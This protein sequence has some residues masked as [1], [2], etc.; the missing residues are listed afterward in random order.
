MSKKKITLNNNRLSSS[1]DG[2]ILI[3]MS[4]GIFLIISIFTFFLMKL[5]VKEHNMSMLH[6][7]DVKTRNLS[8]SAMGRGVFQFNNF[9]DISSQTG[10]LN[11]GNY[12]ISY[13][14][15]NDENNNPLPYSHYT[16]LKSEA[17]I[18]NSNRKTRLFLSSF[19]TGFNPAFYGENSNNILFNVNNISGG[20][21][22]KKDGNLYHNGSLIPSE[23]IAEIMPTFNNFYDDEIIWTE[24]N[25][26]PNTSNS[27]G[28]PNNRFLSFEGNDYAKVIYTSTTTTTTTTP[29]A[30]T[31]HIINFEGQ[32]WQ[33]NNGYAGMNW[34]NRFYAI[35]GSSYSGSGYQTAVRSGSMAAFNAWN[36]QNI[37]FQTSDGSMFNFTELYA[38]SAW[39]NTQ[40][41]TVKG[42]RNNTQVYSQTFNISKSTISRLS[43][44]FTNVNKIQFS[45]S[46]SHIAMDDFKYTKTGP[47]TTTTTTTTITSLPK[48]NEQRTITAWVKPSDN[49]GNAGDIVNTGRTNDNIGNEFFG[50]GRLGDKLFFWGGVTNFTS[51]LTVPKGEW[52]FI[53]ARYDGYKIRLYVNN[54]WQETTLNNFDTQISELFIGGA[55]TNNGT[56]F[57]S[58]FRGGIDEVAV[59][60]ESLSHSE[61]L[62]LYNSGSGNNASINSGNY[63]SKS[64][65]KGY[66]KLNEGGGNTLLDASGNNKN[67]TNYGS[68]WQTGSH[69]QPQ[70]RPLT[71]DTGS[72][73][74]L[75]SPNCGS[76]HTSLCINNKIAV[77][78]DIV[79]TDTDITGSG[80]I[81]STGKITINENSTLNGDIIV[82]AKTIDIT[83]SS[84]GNSSLF[85]SANGPVTIYFE[86][87]GLISNSSNISGFI[88]N[89]GSNNSESF[90]I[91]N[92]S[93]SGAI[94]NYGVNFSINNN[95]TVIGSIVSNYLLSIDNSSNIIKGN[96]PSFYGKNI[97][98]SPSV[99][100]GS[101]LEY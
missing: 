84:L 64:N 18:N 70:I 89:N 81:V 48:G 58:Y 73:L 7:L 42:F 69:T 2:V 43:M 30:T 44:N 83:N 45:N 74:N 34:H 93:I 85:K 12:E 78:Q 54:E 94:L 95:S 86:D 24:N 37:Y 29:G 31:T 36:E 68:V 92:S 91:N 32:N 101:Y 90:L 53:A 99:V 11:S 13:D 80:I 5:V 6:T 57:F 17:E 35:N 33:I 51:N 10:E 79:F 75:N 3:S 55:S 15:I 52:S 50:L 71:F 9:R 40:T 49:N 82:I 98:L 72:Q 1:N 16:M 67:G 38:A 4:I 87:G 96:L 19:P 56:S 27:G 46:C 66:W 100:P 61:I 76:N 60:D 8:H 65:L 39:C 25:I 63:T 41:I 22:I 88:I 62:E 59:W 28:N 97:G 47:P 21:L 14:G 77:N 26:E 20:H 23:G